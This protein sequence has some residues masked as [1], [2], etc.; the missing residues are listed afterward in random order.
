MRRFALPGVITLIAVALLVVLA[1]GIANNGTNSSI[2][3]QV[4]RGDFPAAPN[5][6]TALPLLSSGKR[7]S[8]ADLRGHVVVVNFFAGW[9]TACQ[10]DASIVRK[11]QRMLAKAGGTTLGVTFQ[12]S[13]TDASSYMRQYHLSFPVLHDANGTLA[14][15]YAVDGVPESFIVNPHGKIVA[16]D[17][18]Q[19]SSKWLKTLARAISESA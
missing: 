5:A 4:A 17:R 18:E 6:K 13:S 7:E 16:L 8:L 9:C 1:I 3:N 11:A 10:D 15:A 12:D 2:D 19:L 14:S